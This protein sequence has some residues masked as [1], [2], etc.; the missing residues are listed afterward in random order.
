[1]HKYILGIGILLFSI[2]TGLYGQA[3][4]LTLE[5]AVAR[6]IAQNEAINIKRS[7][8]NIASNKIIKANA[9]KVPVVNAI[10]ATE[11]NNN[12]TGV[13]L[14]TFQPEPEFIEIDEAGVESLTINLGLRADY[15]LLD[16]GQSKVRLQLLQDGANLSLAQQEVLINQT[17]LAVSE[18]YLELLKLQNQA[19]FLNEN[20]AISEARIAKTQDRK[21]FGQATNLDLLRLQTALNED[22]SALDEILLAKNN[23]TRDLNYLMGV[24]LDNQFEAVSLVMENSNEDL[25]ELLSAIELQNPEVLLGKKATALAKNELLLTQLERKP[26]VNTF[27]NLGYFYQTNDV[28]QLAR[29][30]SA[31]LTVGVS[32]RYNI[33]DGG[34]IENQIQNANMN[35]DLNTKKEDQMLHQIK[36]QASKEWHTLQHLQDRLERERTN[37]ETFEETYNKVQ[38]LFSVGKA[39]N[40]DL[41]DAELARL[42]VLLRINQIE[43]DMLKSKIKLKSLKGE[44]VG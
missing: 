16:G 17:V 44:I 38:S 27:A 41:R 28:Q 18:L 37:L 2:T 12:F 6:T 14:R 23:F 33:F 13:K 30:Q 11:Y 42:N 43:I 29:I 34:R 22:L 25:G 20:I 21:Q 19:D 36:T 10:G 4:V 9:G 8:T 31:G 39:N 7:E 15:T 5:E 35:I 3:N 26:T 40:L 32:L 1:M 24:N